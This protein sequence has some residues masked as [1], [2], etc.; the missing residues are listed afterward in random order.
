MT[1]NSWCS[2]LHQL[3]DKWKWQT[4]TTQSIIFRWH[5]RQVQWQTSPFEWSIKSRSWKFQWIF[6]RWQ[7]LQQISKQWKCHLGHQRR[8]EQCCHCLLHWP[9]EQSDQ[10]WPTVDDDRVSC[11]Q[12]RFWRSA[13]K[14]PSQQQ[15]TKQQLCAK[16]WRTV[17]WTPP[18]QPTPRSS[19][20]T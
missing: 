11:G 1:A 12:E 20:W 14:R 6:Q 5:E 4:A 7:S 17:E 10:C 9:T 16:K 3:D 15:S 2:Q 13:N 18:P 19:S 8:Q